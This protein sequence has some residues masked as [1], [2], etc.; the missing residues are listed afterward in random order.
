MKQ[1][2]LIMKVVMAVL[3]VGVVT[4][5]GIYLVRSYQG[6]LTTVKAYEDAV[7]LGVEASGVLVREESVLTHSSAATH[8]VE[9]LPG[10]GE[11]VSSGG[12]VAMLYS[13]GNGLEVSREIAALENEIA[14]LQYIL[15][16]SGKNESAARLDAEVLN[17]IAVLRASAAL[18]DL[19]DLEDD[20]LDLRTLVFKRDYAYGDTNAA[21]AVSALIQEK[22]TQLKAL[23]A[24]LG[25]VSTTLYAPRAGVF[26]GMV[27]GLEGVLTP[28]ALTSMT[29]SGLDRLL[30]QESSAPSTAVGKL[31]T[32]STWYFAAVMTVEES[33]SFRESRTYP[34]LFTHDW[35]GEVPMTLERISDPEDGL[36]LLVFSCRTHLSDTTLLRQ[37]TA[38]VVT[39]TVSG[40]RIPRQALRTVTETVTQ[41]D[42]STREVTTLGV[43]VLVGA[44]A[45]LKEVDVL[46]QDED[47]FLVSPVIKG[48][49]ATAQAKRLQAGDEIIL[50]TKNLYD[51]KVVR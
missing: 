45:E 11:K 39:K 3:L 37:Q 9:L 22:N 12:T 34:L 19:T 10:E 48:T 49:S 18:G 44:K 17:A 8:L 16:S 1:S 15:T 21:Q 36:V 2:N 32:S 14:Q 13:S 29:P 47:S 50:S 46:W 6:G 4:Y 43:Y 20:T 42:G 41:E 40:L 28:G 24:S 38:E 25:A 7:N 23:R 35:S 31:I 5:F 27:D 51:G 33:E 30:G 26:S